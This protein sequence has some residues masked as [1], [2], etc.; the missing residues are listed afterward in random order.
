MRHEIFFRDVFNRDT[1]WITQEALE[2]YAAA[3]I[4]GLANGE[5]IIR[6]WA[7]A[8]AIKMNLFAEMLVEIDADIQ[9]LKEDLISEFG[10]DHFLGVAKTREQHCR[11]LELAIDKTVDAKDKAALY[12][13]LREFRGWSLKPADNQVN[14][15]VSV[16]NNN[17]R[18]TV[19]RGDARE[20]ERIVMSVFGSR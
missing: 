12:K 10:I 2:E 6:K 13:E 4:R 18:I 17:D 14:V 5:I 19:P 11:E 3:T 20:A 16:S 15:S 9:I 7:Q 8:D 1:S